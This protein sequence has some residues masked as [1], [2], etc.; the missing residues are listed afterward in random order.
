MVRRR[1]YNTIRSKRRFELLLPGLPRLNVTALEANPSFARNSLCRASIGFGRACATFARAGATVSGA[2]VGKAFGDLFFGLFEA[3]PNVCTGWVALRSDSGCVI[4]DT[5][6]SQELP[7]NLILGVPD[8]AAAG[9]FDGETVCTG[10]IGESRTVLELPPSV[11]VLGFTW[12][13][14]SWS[15][16]DPKQNEP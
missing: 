11:A 7:R 5:G 16:R 12:K 14:A 4:A 2:E 13:S 8:E 1:K 9:S 6:D 3:L 15:L 10:R